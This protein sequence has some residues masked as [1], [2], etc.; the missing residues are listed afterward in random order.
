MND[1]DDLKLL[2]Q[3]DALKSMV[4]ILI[5]ISLALNDK[6]YFTDLL[7]L[8]NTGKGSLSNHLDILIKYGYIKDKNVFTIGG[9]R[10]LFEI[11]EKGKIFYQN[12]TKIISKLHGNM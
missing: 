12:Y 2:L 4:R 5:L 8:T 9:P 1:I 6:M 11:T 3:D 7:T 10:R